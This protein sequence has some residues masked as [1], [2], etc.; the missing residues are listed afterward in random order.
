[1]LTGGMSGYELKDQAIVD[2]SEFVDNMADHLRRAGVEIHEGRRVTAFKRRSTGV[3]LETTEGPV[4]ADAAVLA[5]GAWSPEVAESL[6]V[7]LPIFPGKG[8][9]FKVP[10]EQPP[11]QFVALEMA[12]VALVPYRGGL[13]IAGTMEIDVDR[14]RFDPGRVEAIV[15]AARPYLRGADWEGR[16]EEWVG[17]RPMTPT[18]LPVIGAL[19]HD[20]RVFVA[21]GHNM[22]GVS[23]APGTG[24]ALAEL[25]T[26]G[27]ASIDLAPFAP[28]RFA[29]NGP[30]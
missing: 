3:T 14:D 2:S 5:A 7:R 17:P 19:D 24:R 10:I 6:G 25:V 29:A 21:A 27:T 23:L 22:L 28:S 15:A 18:G 9:S 11:K 8:Y 16:S 4:S 26:T 12:H 20:R 1:M 30:S 13:R